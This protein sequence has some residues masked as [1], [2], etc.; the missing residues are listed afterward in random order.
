M[1]LSCSAM[2]QSGL[3]DD[4]MILDSDEP[5]ILKPSLNTITIINLYADDRTPN[6]PLGPINLSKVKD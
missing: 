3:D 6:S 1:Q 5:Q 4:D 2:L